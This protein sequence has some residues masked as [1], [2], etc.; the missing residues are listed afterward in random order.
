V[1][2][3]REIIFDAHAQT[4]DV[5]DLLRC[6]G[7]HGARRAWHF[8]E[9]CQVVREGDGLR[10]TSG[11]AIVHMEPC[12]SLERIEVH[13]GGTPQQGGWVSRSFGSKQPSTTVLWYSRIAGDTVLRTRIR[14]TR[15]RPGVL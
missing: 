15:S 9:N 12:E 10:I 2:H 1:V 5:A 7:A 13:R 3:R 8:A 6:A 14:Y 11:C 4:I